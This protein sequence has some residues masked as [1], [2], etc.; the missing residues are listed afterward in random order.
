M[1][2]LCADL[3]SLF[4]MLTKNIPIQIRVLQGLEYQSKAFWKDSKDRCLQVKKDWGLIFEFLL[5][6]VIAKLHPLFSV[7]G[8]ILLPSEIFFPHYWKSSGSS[9]SL[10]LWGKWVSYTTNQWKENRKDSR[11]WG[12]PAS[13]MWFPYRCIDYALDSVSTPTTYCSFSVC[14]HYQDLVEYDT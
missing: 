7:L 12:P 2:F 11:E 10:I 5:Y 6:V 3:H 8:T 14:S 1:S 13:F 4:L 9:C